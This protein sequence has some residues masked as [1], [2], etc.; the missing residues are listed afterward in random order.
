MNEQIFS[1]SV[2]WLIYLHY[3]YESI[4]V[5]SNVDSFPE[6][7]SIKNI[8][9]L[10]LQLKMYIKTYLMFEPSFNLRFGSKSN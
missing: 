7:K 10:L 4:C 5:N 9:R 3:F 8:I 2:I 6:Q 1:T